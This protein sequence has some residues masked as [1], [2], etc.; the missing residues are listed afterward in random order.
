MA[1]LSSWK[2]PSLFL[3]G[4]IVFSMCPKGSM[5]SFTAVKAEIISASGVD[6]DTFPWRLLKADIGNN[7]LGPSRSKCLP[8][9]DLLET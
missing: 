2:T 1:V 9:V 3:P 7:V 5:A 4:R 6:V 8:E